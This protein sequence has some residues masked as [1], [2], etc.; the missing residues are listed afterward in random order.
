MYEKAYEIR[1]E[2]KRFAAAIQGIDID[3]GQKE[4]YFEDVKRRAEAKA[5]GMDE[6]QYS[7]HGMIDV[8]DEDEE[9]GELE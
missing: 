7:L 9:E 5:L 3:E 8:I 4:S 2:D 1:T 6:E